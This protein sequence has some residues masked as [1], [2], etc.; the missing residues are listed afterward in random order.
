MGLQKKLKLMATQLTAVAALTTYTST[1]VVPSATNRIQ[2]GGFRKL[3]A[4]TGAG[5][6]STSP[7]LASD[8]FVEVSGTVATVYLPAV[9]KVVAGK[10]YFVRNNRTASMTGG[11]KT[12][13]TAVPGAT[14]LGAGAT[15][16]LLNTGT[17]W[18]C[19]GLF[20]GGTQGG[21][22]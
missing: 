18:R 10:V 17:A 2:L 9:S 11:I 20:S 14:T 13:S 21:T 1:G 8:Y 6:T 22:A 3:T 15:I 4:T 16:V 19:V 5:G 12:G 7:L